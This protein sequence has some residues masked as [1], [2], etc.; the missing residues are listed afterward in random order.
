MKE[1]R[2]K[3]LNSELQ[4]LIYSILTTKIK[5]PYITEMFSI[6]GVEVTSDLENATAFVSI[7]SAN[8]KASEETFNAICESAPQ[9]RKELGNLMRIRY[10]PKIHFKLDISQEYG[11]KID[12]IISGFT[13][14]E[15]NE[16]E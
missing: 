5:N 1:K 2:E 9:V 16:K 8:S 6:S 7:Y 12:R 15:H 11:E 3:R 4:K 10:I 13:Y 14:G